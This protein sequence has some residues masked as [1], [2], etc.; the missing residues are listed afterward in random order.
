MQ[1]KLACSVC[2]SRRQR[3]LF[4]VD[5]TTH[6]IQKVQQELSETPI[7]LKKFETL[8]LKRFR[9]T[10]DLHTHHNLKIYC[11]RCFYINPSNNYRYSDLEE[12]MKSNRIKQGLDF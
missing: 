10:R 8:I 5:E 7:W 9:L 2:G 4:F 6:E 12:K 11:Y 3:N 1:T